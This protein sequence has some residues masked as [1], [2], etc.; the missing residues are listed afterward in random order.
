MPW[1]KCVGR[2]ASYSVPVPCMAINVD[3]CFFPFIHKKQ[4]M[5]AL[6]FSISAYEPNTCI[7]MIE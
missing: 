3:D 2:E 4:L 1:L 6:Y 5:G 7:L